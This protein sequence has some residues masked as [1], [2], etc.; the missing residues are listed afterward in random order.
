MRS[1]GAEP[2]EDAAQEFGI[3]GRFRLDAG[4]QASGLVGQG[5]GEV[6]P[7]RDPARRSGRRRFGAAPVEELAD[8]G[9]VR[10]RA[11][12]PPA[13]GVAGE[14]PAE[15]DQFDGAV[16]STS[17]VVAPAEM[18]RSVHNRLAR[19]EILNR[20]AA[21]HVVLGEAALWREVGGPSVLLNQVEALREAASR[22][23]VT[24]QVLTFA[25]GEHASLETGFTLLDLDEAGATYAYL[26]DL[27]SSD[28]WDKRSHTDVYEL[29]FSRLCASALGEREALAVLDKAIARLS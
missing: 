16:L 10:S 9:G 15:G 5:A 6:A 13:A 12:V 29:V 11:A 17:V 19:S 24:L 28:F 3:A 2:G 21:V 23:N 1:E 27:T 26:E 4:E 20:A 18:D 22:P 25:A 8:G 7:D 14:A